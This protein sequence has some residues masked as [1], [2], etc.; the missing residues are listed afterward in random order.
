[1]SRFQWVAQHYKT[2]NYVSFTQLN[3][4]FHMR[5]EWTPNRTTELHKD[6]SV[7]WNVNAYYNDR[8]SNVPNF[9]RTGVTKR[10]FRISYAW[11]VLLDR[12]KIWHKSWDYMRVLP[13]V[14]ELK[15]LE[16]EGDRFLESQFFSSVDQI[17][18]TKVPQK[19]Q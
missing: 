7:G 8:Y 9:E 1:M 12:K 13:G 17:Q 3:W 16:N 18:D 19:Y 15:S 4:F 2:P 11:V 5:Y 14:L 6:F 10:E